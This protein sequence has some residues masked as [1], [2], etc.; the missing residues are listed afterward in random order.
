MRKG[1]IMNVKRPRI[2]RTMQIG[3]EKV[4]FIV[5]ARSW[6]GNPAGFKVQCFRAHREPVDWFFNCLQ[7]TEAVMLGKKK[8]EEIQKEE[9]EEKQPSRMFQIMGRSGM[10][11]GTESAR[12][13]QGALDLF[14]QKRH[15]ESW[16]DMNRQLG[17][18]SKYTVQ[19]GFRIM[20]D[21]SRA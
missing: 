5:T 12:T 18:I 20:L 13:A 11:L 1:K 14:A 19:D 16:E 6:Y 15:Y 2:Q 21:Q 17:M 9:L 3:G 8:L 4:K 7:N 10:T